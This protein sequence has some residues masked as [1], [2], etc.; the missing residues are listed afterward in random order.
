[1]YWMIKSVVEVAAT[2]GRFSVNLS[3]EHKSFP[4]D[5]TIQ[6]GDQI[7]CFCFHSELNSRL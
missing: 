5:K 7:I 6:K 3:G 4:A 1:M 2:V